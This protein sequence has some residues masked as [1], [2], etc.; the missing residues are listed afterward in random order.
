M[1]PG[2][3]ALTLAMCRH[4]VRSYGAFWMSLAIYTTLVSA[5]IYGPTPS[6]GDRLMLTLWGIVVR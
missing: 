6:K 1:R 3:C 2:C 5:E 4:P